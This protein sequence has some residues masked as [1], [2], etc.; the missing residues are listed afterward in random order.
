LHGASHGIAAHGAASRSAA[1]P[2]RLGTP[3]WSARA[4]V[5]PVPHSAD[6]RKVLS[7]TAELARKVRPQRVVP[8]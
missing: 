1:L 3:A 7:L 8:L 6:S 4:C 5:R 2:M